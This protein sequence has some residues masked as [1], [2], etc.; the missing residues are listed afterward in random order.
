MGQSHTSGIHFKEGEVKEHFK[1]IQAL[2]SEEDL[3]MLVERLKDMTLNFSLDRVKFAKLLQLSSAYESLVAKWFE[4]FSHD[5]ASQVVDGLEFLSAAIMI[6]SKV[7]LFS[8]ICLV[9]SLFDLDKTGCIRKD[10]FTIFLKAITTGLH[11]TMSGLPPPA[12]V[13]ELGSLSAE[14]F[15]TISN[16]VLSQHDLLM[17]MTEAHYSLHYLSVLSRLETCV[18]TWGTN[19]RQQL[20]LNFEPDLQRVPAPILKLEG[21]KISAIA[22]HESHCLFL[23]D[24]GH[25]WT[26]GSGFCGLLGHG[27]LDNCAQPR[28]LESLT[29]TK[30]VDVAVGVRH[31]VAVSEKGQVFTWGAADMGQL[32]HGPTDDKEVHETAYC[33]KT[34]SSFTY[35][36]K[37]TVVMGL[38]GKRVIAKKVSC[39]NFSTAILSDLGHI[40]TW[41]NNTDGQ[42][43]QGQKCP[44]HK[45]V[46][47]DPHM[48]RTAMQALMFPR[49][50]EASTAFKT[51]VCGGYHMLA[52]DKDNRVWS[53]GQGMWGKLGHGDQRSMYDPQLVDTM[54]YHVNQDLAAGEAHSLCLCSLYRLTITA[55][56]GSQEPSLNAFSLLGLPIGRVDKHLAQRA[57]VTP[58]STSLQLNA[59]ASAPLLQVGLPFR[60]DPDLPIVDPAQYPLQDIVESIVLIDRA[61]WEGQWLKLATTDYD[62]NVMMSPAGAQ[63]SA[64]QGLTGPIMFASEGRWEDSDCT[65]KICIFEELAHSG[66]GLT[67]SELVLPIL[68]LA[69]RCMQAQG[70]CCFCILPKKV[71]VFEVEAAAEVAGVLK[72]LPFG[73]MTYEHGMGLKKH[74]TRLIDQVIAESP[75]GV[76]DEVK[77]WRECREE[78]TGK[79]YFENIATGAKRWAPPQITPA[80]EGSVLIIREDCFLKRLKAILDLQPKG[81]I[82]CQQSWK[83]DVELVTLE[84]S[85]LETL[86]I[87]IVVVTFEA[88]EELKSAVEATKQGAKPYVTMEIQPYGGVCAWGNGTHGQLGLAGIENRNFL[89]R[90]QNVLTNEENTFANRPYYVAHLHEHQVVNLACGMAH[91]M[92]V[93]QQ[94]E[95]F[96]WGAADG[97]GVP[98]SREN[99]EVPMY[100]EQLEGLVK[101]TKAFAG[102]N[103]SFVVAEMPFRSAV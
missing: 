48:A 29:V 2:W 75:D 12:T 69:Q 55:G 49:K 65:G 11:R 51:V 74:I 45:L 37:P 36:P 27:N 43:G 97:L 24:A 42:C 13:M 86:E 32:G 56:P 31:S 66:E 90:T 71:E 98:L 54:K 60:H 64:R 91:T 101:S 88:G 96:T 47:V 61:L 34:G 28:L 62:F 78:F 63:V 59:F 20:G 18:F 67:A 15:D 4:E 100:V 82:V 87:P 16:D 99:S 72:A 44:D 89:T 26:C 52:I 10:E 68:E 93:T 50:I 102:N 92:A 22:S 79:K 39:C 95:V 53:W 41:G 58:P 73:V 76:P 25:V 94:G 103:H 7:Q 5:R 40:F 1:A 3:T 84:D 33:P 38:F 80:T 23:T 6:S 46:Y 14:F 19:Q 83:P 35:V 30:I 77:D 9:F 70:F 85:M 21:I 81:I 8:K 57:P 17:W